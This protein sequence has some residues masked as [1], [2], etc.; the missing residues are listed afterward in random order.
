MNAAE[1]HSKIIELVLENGRVT[2]P[3]ICGAFAIS[4]MTARRDL[5]ELDRQGL[6]RRVHGGAIAN[7]GRSYEPSFQTRAVNNQAAKQAIGLKAADLIYDG[8][9]IALDVGTT[10]LEIVPGL[11]GKRNLTIVTSCL[12]IAAKIVDQIPL[13]GNARLIISGGIVRPRELSMIGPIP[14]QVYQ[15]LH[16]DKAFIGIGG[17]SLE[18]G[19]TE[20]NIEDAQ[21][22]RILIRSAR[23]RIVVA[24]GAKFGVTTFTSVAPLAAVERIV[25]DRSAPPEIVEQVRK[26]G[27]EVIVVD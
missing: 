26:R 15:D 7:L 13:E 12:Q 27:V 8:D 23:E 18:D 14:E 11:R 6:V 20:Y 4:E 25:T 3:D 16:V 2:I 22:K 9:S 10:T 1:R 21:I 19:L 5:N 17:I 24:D